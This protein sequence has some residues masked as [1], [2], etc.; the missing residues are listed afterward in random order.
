MVGLTLGMYNRVAGG[1]DRPPPGVSHPTYFIAFFR[2]AQRFFIICEICFRLA[3]DIVRPGGLPRR[4]PWPS[5]PCRAWIAAS[6]LLRSSLSW[7]T[8]SSM[9]MPGC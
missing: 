3:A 4:L 1:L 8:I 2:S 6:S 5:V 7:W 9:F